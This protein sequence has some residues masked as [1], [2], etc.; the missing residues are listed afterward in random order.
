[1]DD[2]PINTP[3][4]NIAKII[5]DCPSLQRL[6]DLG[7]DLS[8]W[9]ENDTNGD[10]M[11]IALRLNFESEV[12]PRIQWLMD[13]GIDL[14]RQAIMFT[15]N[16]KIFDK[17][18]E[19]INKSIAY[20]KSKD[21]TTRNIKEILIRS[22][23]KWLDYSVVDIDSKLG[24]FQRNFELIGNEVRQLTILEPCLILWAGVPFQ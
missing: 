16:P 12:K 23:G 20:L 4:F 5:S 14:E 10:N 1:M 22:D 7:V 15:N 24:Y 3:T 21:F 9:E 2:I 13:H 19:E 8:R 17:S 11:E 18:F 6:V